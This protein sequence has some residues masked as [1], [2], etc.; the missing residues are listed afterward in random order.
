MSGNEIGRCAELPN[1]DQLIDALLLEHD[2][3][4]GNGKGNGVGTSSASAS[5]DIEELIKDGIAEPK[6]S[7]AFSRVVWSLAGQGF[8]VEEIEARLREHPNGIAEKFWARLPKEIERSFKKWQRT[9]DEQDES[10]ARD[11]AEMNEKYA[12][13]TVGSNVRIMTLTADPTFYRQ[14]DFMLLLKNRDKQIGKQRV[15]L[16]TWWLAHSGRRQYSGVVFEPGAPESVNGKRNLWTGW[17]SS[18]GRATAAS[19]SRSCIR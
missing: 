5:D 18:R 9:Q 14:A 1:I 10:D 19:I 17:A 3:H 4:K 8:S 16:S 15:P 7:Q 12:V 6:R 13:V 11:L 2:S